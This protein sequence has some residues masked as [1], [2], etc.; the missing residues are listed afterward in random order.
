MRRVEVIPLAR[1]N[2]NSFIDELSRSETKD[3]PQLLYRA[4]EI[5]ADELDKPEIAK[6]IVIES[7]KAAHACAVA[8]YDRSLSNARS[9]SRL[10][11]SKATASISTCIRDTRAALRRAL[12][13]AAQRNFVGDHVD[14]EVMVGFLNDCRD[15]TLKFSNLPYAARILNELGWTENQ[16]DVSQPPTLQLINEFEAMHPLDRGAIEDSLKALL[17]DQ[18]ASV[19]AL[20][21]FSMISDSLEVPSA[22]EYREYVGDLNITM[23]QK[24]GVDRGFVRLDHI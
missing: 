23:S 6:E 13:D 18:S 1:R 7:V 11:V 16:D 20:N 15:A 2:V 21:I 22:A 4:W 5:V 12:N 14:A 24:S 8:A 10:K 3:W 19:S 17:K 9:Q